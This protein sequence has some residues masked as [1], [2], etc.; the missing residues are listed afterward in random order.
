MSATIIYAGLLVDKLGRRPLLLIGGVFAGI[1]MFYLAGYSKI[2]G[3]FD[4]IPP[5]DSGARLAVAMVYIYALFYGLS[6]NGV[7]WLFSSEVMPN[8]VRTLAM[9]FV[10]CIQ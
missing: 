10:I 9:T 1:A 5:M 8:R 6:W 7:P 3:S 2:S 4:H